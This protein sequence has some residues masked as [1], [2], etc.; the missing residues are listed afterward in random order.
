MAKI[1]GIIGTGSGR[2]GNA[3]LSKGDNGTTVARTY[4]SQVRNPRTIDQRKQRAK[5]NLAAQISKLFPSSA[6]IGMQQ[7]SN[8]NNRSA[9]VKNLLNACTVAVNGSGEYTATL[10]P[11]KL[12][13]A[14]GNTPFVHGKMTIGQYTEEIISLSTINFL[15]QSG[16]VGFFSLSYSWG[17]A[18]IGATGSEILQAI[19]PKGIYGEVLTLIGLSDTDGTTDFVYNFPILIYGSEMDPTYTNISSF[20][21]YGFH[22]GLTLQSGQKAL[23]YRTPFL[24]GDE[25]TAFI[26][27]DA[28]ISANNIIASCK[29]PLKI[30][31]L[32]DTYYTFAGIPTSVVSQLCMNGGTRW[33]NSHYHGLITAS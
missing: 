8:R 2:L 30:K 15:N 6:L 3:V 32:L 16:S 7:G 18:N 31:E 24:L 27:D 28:A 25:A 14:H 9:F 29:T 13:V 17:P 23:L 26:T 5:M 10:V 4:Q 33:G 22:L 11:D 20:V 19:N 21:T 12:S 1:V